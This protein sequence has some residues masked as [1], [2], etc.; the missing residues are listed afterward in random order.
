[1]NLRIQG[2]QSVVRYGNHIAHDLSPVCILTFPID[3][4]QYT[5]PFKTHPLDGVKKRHGKASLRR[6]RA[7]IRFKRYDLN[8]AQPAFSDSTST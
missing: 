4:R 8:P 2:D 3:E 5:M 7:L 6:S 1:M